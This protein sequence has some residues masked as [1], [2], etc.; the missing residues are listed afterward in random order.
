[1][2]LPFNKPS[3]R[4]EQVKSEPDDSDPVGKC[5]HDSVLAVVVC[6]DGAGLNATFQMVLGKGVDERIR[7]VNFWN[8]GCRSRNVAGHFVGAKG[9]C[10]CG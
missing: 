4:Q 8:L 10:V 6:L 7:A 5:P 1:M 3:A 2:A 9:A